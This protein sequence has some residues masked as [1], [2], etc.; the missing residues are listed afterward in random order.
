MNI[1]ASQEG[2][3]FTVDG[4]DI[5]TLDR[6]QQ[7]SLMSSVYGLFSAVS[8]ELRPTVEAISDDMLD[9]FEFLKRN[10][11][12][13]F[14]GTHLEPGQM[15][16]MSEI[17]FGHCTLEEVGGLR[18]VTENDDVIDDADA[19]DEQVLFA[20]KDVL[21]THLVFQACMKKTRNLLRRMELAEKKVLVAAQQKLT[22]SIS[23]VKESDMQRKLREIH[24]SV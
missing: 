19:T 18:L 1:V 22:I 21:K 17:R 8:D 16:L 2:Q 11:F 4:V 10:G 12:Y 20:L 14:A 15:S 9:S 13:G 6:E 5:Q 3:S 24:L 7:L 23:Q